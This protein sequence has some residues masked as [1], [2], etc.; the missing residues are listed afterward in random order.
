MIFTLNMWVVLFTC[1]L[2]MG[3]FMA[4]LFLLFHKRYTYHIH[5][6][7]LALIILSLLLFTEIAEE[8][9]LVDS[10]PSLLGIGTIIDL[11]FWPFILFYVQYISDNRDSYGWSDL[12]YFSPFLIALLG[13]IPFLLLP[14][15]SKLNY[16]ATGIPLDTAILVGFKM[17]VSLAFLLY[18]INLINK[19][20]VYF[21]KP[22]PRNK[23]V[24]FLFRIRQVLVGVSAIVLF[25]Y[26]MFFNNYFDF[27]RL[28]DSDRIGSLIISALFYLFGYLVFRSPQLFQEEN[29]TKQVIDFFKGR[30]ADYVEEL[31]TLFTDK[32]MYLNEKL[33]VKDVAMEMGLT[34]QQLSY[35]INRQLGISYTDFVN[36]YRVM[37]VQKNLQEGKH[38][39]KTLLGL[40]LASGFNSK[41]SFNRIFKN[42]TGDSPSSYLKKLKKVDS[43]SN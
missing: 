7:T 32:K 18:T 36:T 23:K 21:K 14:E 11:L 37:E 10:F 28:G 31:L 2:V 19:R 6:I 33:A 3:L 40:A 26:F 15:E 42:H 29:Y 22:F 8:S 9:N 24:V 30:E 25:I 5:N 12:L 38:Q 13:L 35:L 17:F 34:N 16:Y 4:S 20:L 39:L 41:A 43:N 27:L 1:G